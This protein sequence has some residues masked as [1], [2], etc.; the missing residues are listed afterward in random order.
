MLQAALIKGNIR[1]SVW[2]VVEPLSPECVT[3]ADQ[4]IPKAHS[5][6]R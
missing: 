4:T 5:S 3:V 1:A 2:A 6:V